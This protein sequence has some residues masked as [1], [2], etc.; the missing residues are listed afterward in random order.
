MTANFA[1][2][3]LRIRLDV[4]LSAPTKQTHHAEAGGERGSAHRG[5]SDVVEPDNNFLAICKRKS[6][7]VVKLA[8]RACYC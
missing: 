3:K 1:K 8:V 6:R 7:P 5:S 2:I 4:L